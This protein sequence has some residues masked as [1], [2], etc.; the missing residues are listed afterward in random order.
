MIWMIVPEHLLSIFRRRGPAGVVPTVPAMPMMQEMHQ[1]TGQQEKIR[2]DAQSVG[3][4]L[5]EQK[6][7]GNRQEP[8]EQQ[9]EGQSP[10][11]C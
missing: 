9:P 6:E 7:C 4:V 1:W 2:Q 10:T 3:R 5:R 11:G 8:D